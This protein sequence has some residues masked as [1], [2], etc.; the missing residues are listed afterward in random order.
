M[1]QPTDS[2]DNFRLMP[3]QDGS[4]T[5]HSALHDQCFHSSA[6]A[7]LESQYIYLELGLKAYLAAEAS[8][9]KTIDDVSVE[10]IDSQMKTLASKQKISVL[11][12]GFGTAGIF[13]LGIEG[14]IHRCAAVNLAQ[15]TLLLQ[16]VQV[17][18]HGFDGNTK[19]LH[20]L[21]IGNCP[22]PGDQFHD[23][24]SAL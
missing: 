12:I 17:T 13:R 10:T 15:Y 5:I 19:P 24:T 4:L 21:C 8:T 18:A 6:G 16:I 9:M 3:C 22:L 1:M 20:Q 23:L 11:E 2:Q 14:N 7:L